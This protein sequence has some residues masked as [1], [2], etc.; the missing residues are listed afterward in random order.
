MDKLFDAPSGPISP[1]DVRAT[2]A[3]EIRLV[4]YNLEVKAFGSLCRM[5]AD[6]IANNDDEQ[7]QRR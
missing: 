6:E 7:E 1:Q 2:V 4:L 5:S 3:E